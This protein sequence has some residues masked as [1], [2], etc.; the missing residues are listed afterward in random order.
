MRA[1]FAAST[2]TP[3][4]SQWQHFLAVLVD[5]HEEEVSLAV[6]QATRQQT[7]PHRGPSPNDIKPGMFK[8]SRES[9]QSFRQWAD[10]MAA[11]LVRLDPVMML[12]IEVASSMSEWDSTAFEKAVL[13]KTKPAEMKE[14]G[15]NLLALVKKMTEGEA[16]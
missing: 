8:N 10:D 5:A 14:D 6:A 2:A 12:L 1:R 16:R 9:G 15:C 11:W 4:P 7:T 3:D 13:A